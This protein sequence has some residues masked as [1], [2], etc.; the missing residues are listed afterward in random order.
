[1]QEKYANYRLDCL[2]LKKTPM[3]YKQ[4]KMSYKNKPYEEEWLF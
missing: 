4:F 3:S 1:M 2:F